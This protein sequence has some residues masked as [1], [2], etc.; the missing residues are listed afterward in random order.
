MTLSFRFDK[1]FDPRAWLDLYHASDYNS[2]WTRRNAEAMLAHAWLVVS[3]WE[4]GTMIG[5][6]TVISDGVNYALIEDV[7]VHPA[8]RHEGIGSTL[9]RFALERLGRFVPGTVQLHATPG[10]EPFYEHLGFVASKSP[11]MYWRP[12]K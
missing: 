8:R 7:V 1:D 9:M 11:V 5:S 3:A 4:G 10:V 2:A 6:V 12:N